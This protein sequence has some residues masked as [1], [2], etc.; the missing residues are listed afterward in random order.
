MRTVV[1]ATGVQ[2]HYPNGYRNLIRPGERF[3][4]YRGVG[5]A[6]KRRGNAEY[7]GT[8]PTGEV[9]RDDKIPQ[10]APKKD[11][12]WFCGI[13]SYVPFRAPVVAKINGVFFEVLPPNGWRM[14]VRK[15][16]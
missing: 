12:Q 13:E 3:V 7:F 4:Y 15:I 2:Y 10:D 6:G 1:D 8:G 5:R 11:W 9:W 16:S 14:A